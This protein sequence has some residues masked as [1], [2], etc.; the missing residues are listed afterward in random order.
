[1]MLSLTDLTIGTKSM[2]KDE[3]RDEIVAFMKTLKPSLHKIYHVAF[4]SWMNTNKPDVMDYDDLTFDDLQ[5]A[6]TVA[7]ASMA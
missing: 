6:D 3:K 5:T 4:T 1:M 7:R 2:T